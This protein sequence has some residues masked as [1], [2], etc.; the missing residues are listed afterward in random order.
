MARADNRLGK[1]YHQIHDI[2]FRKR[3][4]KKIGESE[5]ATRKFI[6]DEVFNPGKS[7]LSRKKQTTFSKRGH[8]AMN[9]LLLQTRFD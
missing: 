8:E 2:Y 6:E 5:Y 9:I 1:L 4:R 7:T 3:N